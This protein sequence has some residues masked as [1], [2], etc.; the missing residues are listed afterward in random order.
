MG[1]YVTTL[2]LLT[3]EAHSNVLRQAGTW[4]FWSMLAEWHMERHSQ[5]GPLSILVLPIE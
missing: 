2:R 3:E 4:L 5:T 1:E